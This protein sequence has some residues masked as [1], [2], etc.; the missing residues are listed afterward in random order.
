MDTVWILDAGRFAGQATSRYRA[1]NA[2]NLIGFGLV[3]AR[4]ESDGVS[5]GEDLMQ[6]VLRSGPI[7][8]YSVSH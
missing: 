6:V 7:G 1:D 4:A 2:A 8:G 5:G 3:A